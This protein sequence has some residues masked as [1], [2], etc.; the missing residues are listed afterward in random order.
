MDIS[1]LSDNSQ[2]SISGDASKSFR[3]ADF[4]A[5]MLTEITNQDPFE[6]Q[7]TSKL[8]ENMQKLQDLANSNYEKFRADIRWAQDLVG[9]EVTALQVNLPDDELAT[10]A[11][12]GI[13]PDVGY[14]NV[15]GPIE[16]FRTVAEQVWV[17]IGGKDYPIDNVQQVM[18]QGY[19][20][21]QAATLADGLIDQRVF[22][23]D[24]ASG[25]IANGTVTGVKWNNDGEV[26][27]T[28]DDEADVDFNDIRSITSGS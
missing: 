15:S 13:N 1:A 28:I 7:E 23:F 17:S 2:S 5:I 19:D 10:L 27:L 3:T 14:N 6:P 4:L 12:R 11:E 22:Y 21:S 26:T 16:S 9:Q 8:V 24:R 20:P 25:N 18:P